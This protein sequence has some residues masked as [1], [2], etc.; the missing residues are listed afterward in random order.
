[1]TY[2]VDDRL[3]RNAQ[4]LVLDPRR[5]LA[6]LAAD[7]D[8]EP[9]AAVRRQPR[10]QLVQRFLEGA[11]FEYRRAQVEDRLT[12]ITDVGF[13]LKPE[14]LEPA[15][16]LGIV[17]RRRVLE[18]IEVQADAEHALE[19]RV[20]DLAADARSLGKDGR[21]LPAHE[22]GPQP[23]RHGDDRGQCECSENSEPP[24]LEQS[25]RQFERPG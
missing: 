1:M 12:R 10:G 17:Q 19:Q 23:P 18:V 14:T 22:A 16:V 4:E 7:L 5:A 8:R 15:A 3:V 24:R 6:R 2:G 21:E 9:Q 20:V 13:E 11:V 25:G